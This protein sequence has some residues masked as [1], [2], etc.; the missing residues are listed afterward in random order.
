MNYHTS[1]ASIQNKF[2]FLF[3]IGEEGG[4]PVERYCLTTDTWKSLP[5][6]PTN[7][8]GDHNGC[9]LGNYLYVFSVD[10]QNGAASIA[11]LSN[12]GASNIEYYLKHWVL[13]NLPERREC[14]YDL[15]APLNSHEILIYGGNGG[16]DCSTFDTKRYGI[17]FDTNTNLS[18]TIKAAITS[19]ERNQSINV[20]EDKVV[21]LVRCYEARD[22]FR[23]VE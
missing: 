6:L 11:K 14:S 22:Y 7:T 21:S 9:V 10:Y 18:Y 1:L 8:W 16:Y 19:P 4:R 2:V 20:G 12:P 15:F 5:Q 17:I 23:L 13:I 3:G